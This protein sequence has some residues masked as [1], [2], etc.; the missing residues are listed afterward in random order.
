MPHVQRE[1]HQPLK[2]SPSTRIRCL[3]MEFCLC[4][5]GL[6]FRLLW[7]ICHRISQAAKCQRCFAAAH[8]RAM[9][10]MSK[11]QAGRARVW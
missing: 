8:R 5:L 6:E 10:G 4:V 2:S 3:S 11:Y 7:I 9:S 1:Q